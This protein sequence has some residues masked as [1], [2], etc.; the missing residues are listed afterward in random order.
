[1]RKYGIENFSISLLEETD[2]PEQQEKYWIEKLKTFK[3]GYNATIGGD[4]KPYLD[5]DLLIN[6]YK[7]LQSLKAVSNKFKCDT[8][9]LSKILKDNNIYVHSS[10]EVNQIKQ[11]HIVNQYDLNGNYL[12]TYSS[13]L[14]ALRAVHPNNQHKSAVAHITDV[15]K[16]RRK[17]AYG[18]IWRFAN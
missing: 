12:N 10:Q 9:Y 5:Y 15:C 8:H 13:C 16:G 1:M 6:A 17:T 7:E 18:Y 11:G 2:Q 14:A 4:G 3:Y